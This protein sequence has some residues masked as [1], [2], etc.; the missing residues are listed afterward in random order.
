MS[1]FIV[2]SLLNQEERTL[3]DIG[4][5]V[6]EMGQLTLKI[7]LDPLECQHRIVFSGFDSMHRLT[8]I[9]CPDCHDFHHLA[10]VKCNATYA[11][12]KHPRSGDECLELC[13]SLVLPGSA[14]T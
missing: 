5:A 8:D 12:Q 10:A 6:A 9:K 1:A 4:T 13:L 2:G 3:T 7:Y 11:T 14:G